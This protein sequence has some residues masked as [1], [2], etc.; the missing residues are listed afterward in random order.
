MNCTGDTDHDGD[1]N[2][3]GEWEF[4]NLAPGPHCFYVYATDKAGN[5]GSDHQLL[6]D[7]HRGSRRRSPCPRARGQSTTVHTAFAAPLVAKVT[8][9]AGDPV[10]G[11]AGDL[12]APTSVPSGTFASCPGGNPTA[13]QCTVTTNAAGLA[14]SSVFTANDLRR[15]P[16]PGDGQCSRGNHPGRLQ[17]DQHR[18]GGHHPRGVLRDRTVGHRAHRLRRPPGG[19]GDRH[20]RQPGVRGDGDLRPPG[21]G[22]S[23][24]F[25]GSVNT[26]VT[27]A[28]GL[29]TSAAFTANT[30]AGSYTVSAGAPGHQH[31]HLQLDQHRRLGHHPGGVL[32]FGTVRRVH[33]A[34][35]APWWPGRPTPTAIRCRG[36]G[37]LRPT[38]D[39]GLGHLR[40]LGQHRGDQRAP[41]SPPRRAHRQHLR[42]GP[43]TVT[44]R[45]PGHSTPADFS[46][47]NTAGSATTLA[48]SSGSGQ[49]A[50][51]HT[52]FGAPLVAK[53]TD[54]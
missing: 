50:T 5:V 12:R 11:V 38:G 47:T 17:P 28:S 31:G 9:S 46:L 3:E 4:D 2:V 39:R 48:V 25:A 10:A 53:A 52:A 1:P 26:A 34:F 22:A 29:A 35:A 43:Y 6:L 36:D 24:T 14:T 7:H 8:D 32:R 44:A 49:S 16:I 33:A 19:Q 13:T 23:G 20:L 15:W 37:D 27:N 51:V 40:R 42:G 18:R 41:V 45:R 54:T 30:S 21:T